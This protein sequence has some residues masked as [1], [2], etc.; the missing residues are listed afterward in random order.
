MGARGKQGATCTD[1]RLQLT[2]TVVQS[3]S[4]R[5]IDCAV[6][7]P[8]LHRSDALIE[9]ICAPICGTHPGSTRSKVMHDSSPIARHQPARSS[10]TRRKKAPSCGALD[11]YAGR[12]R[13]PANSTIENRLF[14]TYTHRCTPM[15]K[16]IACSSLSNIY[17]EQKIRLHL[18]E[19]FAAFVLA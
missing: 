11:Q 16:S 5:L 8:G 6:V 7:S 3:A 9:Q 19:F 12:K 15:S 4:A 10:M 14:P 18:H 17:A 13:C 2:G 1:P